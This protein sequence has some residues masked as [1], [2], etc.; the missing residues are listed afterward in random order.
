MA[1]QEE[2][3]DLAQTGIDS[4][5]NYIE[6]T[7]E[8]TSNGIRWQT[9][10]F[11][12]EPVYHSR[13]FG[14]CAGI[15]F[16]LADH[17]KI[18]GIEKTKDLAI[19]CNKWCL[20]FDPQNNVKGL[21]NGHT[22]VAFS[23]LH[24]ANALQD[25][26][27]LSPCHTHANF[28][29]HS[30]LGPQTEIFCGVAGDGLFLHH[31]WKTTQDEKYLKGAIQH[32]EWLI[33]HA[34]YNEHG[35]LWPWHLK[36]EPTLFGFAH[37]NS[38]IAHFLLLLYET[39]QDP[40]WKTI[41]QSVIETLNKN[42]T[43]DQGGFHWPRIPNP[44][45]NEIL[46]CQW[47]NGSPG[48]GLFFAKAYEIL[49]DPSL[50]HSA[51]KAGETTY[52]YGDIRQNPTQ[53]HGLAGNAELFIELYRLTDEQI[54]LDRAFDFAQQ[55]FQYRI[56]TKDGDIWQSDD[57]EYYSQDF[58]YGAAGVGHFFLRLM[59]PHTLKMPLS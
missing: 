56:T 45:P 23:Q 30:A 12:N 36:E 33:K 21:L 16:F 48:I 2:I 59:H 20:S 46:R 11:E 22:G 47:C 57:A 19:G 54:W 43:P 29:L 5:Y 38:G 40:K 50:L 10:G 8:T 52:A 58:C 53:C 44:D 41:V 18:Y 35:C 7:A 1:T 34:T 14:G 15:S 51:Q 31:L 32:G 39:T 4:V 3:K 49:N 37:G 25:K 55:A 9:L 13:I 26:T 17:Y 6:R 27:W 42:A 24:L 28:L